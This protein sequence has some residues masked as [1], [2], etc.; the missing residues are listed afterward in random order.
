MSETEFILEKI[1][2]LQ[3]TQPSSFFPAGTFPAFRENKKLIYKRPD[4][5]IFATA[6]TIF[7]LNEIKP[8][9]SEK[10]QQT[11]ETL[12]QNAQRSYSLYKNKDELST[13]NF[14]KTRPS[15]HFPNGFILNKLRHFKLPDD[16]DD[17]ALIFLTSQR[18][19][20]EK[21]WLK[22]KLTQ[23]TQRTGEPQR[24]VY[25]TWFGVHMPIEQDVCALCNLMYWVLESGFELNEYDKATLAY[26][27]EVIVS[28]NFLTNPFAPARH[29]ATV[30]LICYHY[31]RLLGKFNIP[32]LR[33]ADVELQRI[34]HFLLPNERIGLNKILLETALMKLQ[35]STAELPCEIGKIEENRAEFYSFIGA[36]LAPY[37]TPILKRLA[38]KSWARFGWKCEA[39][40][41]ALVI[42]N[43]IL[44]QKYRN[45]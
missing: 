5:N 9:V 15:K 11:I 3:L 33:E 4:D 30:P 19:K 10:Q 7:I 36:F 24:Y 38:S 1:A 22:E 6:S 17:T 43:K 35:K 44:R 2:T 27:N 16:I 12:S 40:E 14:W 20:A 8:F 23:H 41:L 37:D 26:L 28:G 34:I 32:E 13:Y 42:E 29:Y 25:S 18:T 21:T 45:V 31:A 39:H